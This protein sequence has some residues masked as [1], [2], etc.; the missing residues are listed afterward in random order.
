MSLEKFILKK[1]IHHNGYTVTHTMVNSGFLDQ[2]I[3]VTCE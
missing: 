3:D 2:I 1:E